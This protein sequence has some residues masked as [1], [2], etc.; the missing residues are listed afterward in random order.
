M[1]ALLFAALLSCSSVFADTITLSVPKIVCSSCAEKI[2]EALK[3]V[4]GIQ[5]VDVNTKLKQVVIQAPA[6]VTDQ[7]IRDAI[8]KKANYEVKSLTRSL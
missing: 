8:E 4:S 2:T 1:K 5:K 3:S 7:S 6:S